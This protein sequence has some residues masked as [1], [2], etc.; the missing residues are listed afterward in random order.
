MSGP[1]SAV[2][3]IQVKTFPNWEQCRAYADVHKLPFYAKDIDV[4]AF[5]VYVFSIEGLLKL[6]NFVTFMQMDAIVV[7]IVPVQA[8]G[9]DGF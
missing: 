9:I 1:V 2:G 8:A 5:R 7:N 6:A 4:H 3:Y